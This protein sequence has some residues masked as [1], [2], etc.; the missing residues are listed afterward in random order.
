MF[1]IVVLMASTTC[2]S[3]IAHWDG[4]KNASTASQSVGIKML[5]RKGDPNAKA[6]LGWSVITKLL[7][8]L[9]THFLQRHRREDDV[10]VAWR[11]SNA[12]RSTAG[13][14]EI[15]LQYVSQW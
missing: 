10:C 14:A 3:K 1:D 13:V 7:H 12:G 4:L 15:A 9:R 2:M 11:A 6:H 8:D 5:V